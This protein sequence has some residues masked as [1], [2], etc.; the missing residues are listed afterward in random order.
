MDSDVRHSVVEI[1]NHTLANEPVL[2]QN[3][4]C[5]MECERSGF[6][7]L[8]NLFD[9]QYKQLNILDQIARRSRRLGGIAVA[10]AKNFFSAPG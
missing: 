8:N 9:S 10:P 7:E 1:L 6:F 4:Q 2:T 3:A 5:P